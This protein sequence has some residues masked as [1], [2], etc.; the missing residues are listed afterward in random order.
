MNLKKETFGTMPDGVNVEKIKIQNAS[1]ISTE[2]INYGCIITSLRMPG[3]D[4]KMGNIVLGMDSLEEYFTKS[5]F[6]GA[7]VGRFANRISRGKFT[8]DGKEYS[9][10]CNDSYGA[11]EDEVKNHLHGGDRG[12]DK[13]VWQAEVFEDD[14]SAGVKFTYLS[15]DGEEGY[16]GNLDITALY[17]LNDDNELIF[18]YRAKTDKATPVNLTNHSYWNLAGAGSGSIRDHELMLNCPGYLPID[19]SLMPTGEVKDVAGTA[20]DFTRAKK[21]GKDLD[22][23]PGGYDHC[24]TSPGC[25]LKINLIARV[26]EPESG[27]GMDI[28]TTKPAVQFYGGNFL[29]G[30]KGAGGAVF[31]KHGAF[32]LETEHYPDA[33]NQP[34]FPSCILRPGEIYHH[35]TVHRFFIC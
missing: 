6:F 28:F 9:L 10:A 23:V 5:P 33:V 14:N 24:F 17:I 1:G 21:I 34:S 16:P 2:I 26:Y 15:P 4:G 7:I 25:A 11:G 35:R 22:N 27:R 20:M 3:R 12:Y 31:D 19:A 29:D 30:L 13:I 18:D 32:C 8:L